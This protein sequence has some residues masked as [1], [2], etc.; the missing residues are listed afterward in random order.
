MIDKSWIGKSLPA[1]TV[2]VEKGQLKFFAKSVGEK[3]SLYTDEEVARA[4][5]Y[6][7]LPAPPTFCFSLSLASPDP[8]AKYAS[9]GVDP[10]RILHG[11]Q[12]FEYLAPVCAGDTITLEASVVDIYEKKGGALEF[13]KEETVATNQHGEVVAKLFSTLVIRH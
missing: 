8:L 5:G 6:R 1:L 2:D 13:L 10:N 12:S 4:A 3:N 11:D 9:M 7:A